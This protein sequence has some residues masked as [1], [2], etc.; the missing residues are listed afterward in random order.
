[1]IVAG[2]KGL[3]KELLDIFARRQQLSNL[4]FFDNVSPDAPDHLFGQFKILRT[5]DQVEDTFKKLGDFSFALGLGN[6]VLRQILA[7]QFLKIGGVLT[8]VIS[9]GADIGS[10]GVSIRPGCCILSGV[11]ITSSVQI[12]QGCL[13][14]PNA[15]ISHDSILEDFVEL[16]PGANVTGNCKIGGYSFIGANA[17]VLPK[18]KIGKNAIVGAGAVVTKD[19]ADN[20]VVAGVP[21]V[22]KKQ[23][24][25]IEF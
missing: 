21:A 14:N 19:V 20:S 12:G 7:N 22:V 16:S 13:I 5:F 24:P 2:A 23:N 8:S 11:V 9:P 10:F 17:V 15:T 6:P 1:M 25:P 4:Y 3:A 18:I